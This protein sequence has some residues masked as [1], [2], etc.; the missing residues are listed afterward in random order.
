MNKK[1][2]DPNIKVNLGNLLENEYI[3]QK[4]DL[5]LSTFNKL[6]SLF[7][8]F[9]NSNLETFMNPLIYYFYNI[10]LNKGGDILKKEIDFIINFFVNNSKNEKDIEICK[11]LNKDKFVEF[12]K[13]L[14][15]KET[16]LL[17]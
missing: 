14:T 10:E 6:T 16:L 7:E 11:N 1:L 3:N 12:V 5:T 15:K 2:N 4:I 9:N 17:K 13:N 8:L